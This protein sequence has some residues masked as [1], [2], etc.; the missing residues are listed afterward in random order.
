MLFLQH[1][2]QQKLFENSIQEWLIAFGIATAVVLVVGLIRSLVVRRLAALAKRTSTMVDDLLVFVVR[3]THLLLVWLP[4]FWLVGHS[5]DLPDR[6]ALFVKGAASLAMVLQAG[7]WVGGAIDFWIATSRERAMQENAG[8]ATSLGALNFI[9]KVVLWAFLVLVG[10]DNIGVNVTAM[11]A[12]LGVGG[13]AVALAVQNI[14]GDLFASLS[15]VIDKPFVIG[16]FIIVGDF[17]GTVE[18][19]GLKTTR[20]RSLGGE[21]LIFANSDLLKAR[22]R[23]YK[24]MQERRIVFKFGILYET[25]VDKLERVADMVRDI[26]KSQNL[27]RFDRAHFASFGD[28]SYDFEVVYWM[29]DP[30]FNKYMDTQQ[31]INLAM[32]RL[33][34]DEGIGFAYPTQTLHVASPVQILGLAPAQPGP[35]QTS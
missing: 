13:I 2:L 16:D 29:L 7:L 27:V 26:I 9:T 33:F 34:A 23:N 25:P 18:H 24:R 15:I 30:D 11:V 12:G 1:F 17:M 6:V 22:V 20:L 28:S 19:V 10:L 31:L 8:A 32:V 14:L 35:E 4:A 5:L 3:Q 21:Q